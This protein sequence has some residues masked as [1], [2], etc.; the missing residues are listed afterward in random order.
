MVSRDVTLGGVVFARRW[1]GFSHSQSVMVKPTKYWGGDHLRGIRITFRDIDEIGIRRHI[2]QMPSYGR[3]SRLVAI[4]KLRKPMPASHSPH[5]VQ[6][7]TWRLKMTTGLILYA[8]RPERLQVSQRGFLPARETGVCDPRIVAVKAIASVDLGRDRGPIIAARHS[9]SIDLNLPNAGKAAIA[10]SHVT[11]RTP[12]V[13][14]VGVGGLEPAGCRRQHSNRAR[15]CAV[16]VARARCGATRRGCTA[17]CGIAAH[18]GARRASARW[19]RLPAST[20]RCGASRRC[21]A[22]AC[23]RAGLAASACYCATGGCAHTPTTRR[24]HDRRRRR[25]AARRNPCHQK[26]ER[27]KR[28]RLSVMHVCLLPAGILNA[29]QITLTL[30]VFTVSVSYVNLSVHSIQS[31]NMAAIPGWIADRLPRSGTL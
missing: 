27:R 10:A 12:L 31:S 23:A 17:G 20:A 21:A 28:T 18:A 8:R 4:A 22:G 15:P 5:L 24:S 1:D 6:R 26:D 30:P 9:L 13:A 7:Q 29:A 16:R 3:L 25:R 19:V 14:C 2:R 11:G